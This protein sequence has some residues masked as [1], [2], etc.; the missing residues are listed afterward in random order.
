MNLFRRH[1][2]LVIAVI[3]ILV[4]GV[5]AGI[6]LFGPKPG[7]ASGPG[8]APG[9]QAQGGARPGGPGGPGGAA[10]GRGGRGGP[11]LV[12]A[13]PVVQRPFTDRVEVLGVA[14]GQQ[15]VTLTSNQAEMVTA[16]RFRPGQRVSKGQVLLDLKADEE[17]AQIMQAQAVVNQAKN[18]ADRWS[19]LADRGVAP[20]ASA[21]QYKS[22]YQTAQANLRAAQARRS[23]RV[24]RA[25][26]AGTI[27]LSDIAPGAL[28]SPGTAIATLDDTSV[29]HVDFDV[30]D[31]YLSVIRE[32]MAI[33]ATS[34]SYP[35]INRDGRI[36]R[37]DT[38]ID[39]R[40]RAVKA[41][42][43]FRNSDGKVK[44]GMLM[45]VGIQ[46][47]NRISMAVP[48]SA[49]QFSGD[50][51]YVYVINPRAAT[52][53]AGGPGQP[54]AGQGGPGAG[55]NAPAPEAKGPPASGSPGQTA[56]GPPGAMAGRG[57]GGPG[58]GTGQRVQAPPCFGSG[59]SS[60]GGRPGGPD[61]PGQAAPGAPGARGPSGAPPN[62][63]PQSKA[64]NAATNAAAGAQAGG[65]G[66][67]G[68][69]AGGRPGQAEQRPVLAGL[70]EGGYVEIKDGLRADEI[71]VSD[72]LNKLQPGQAVNYCA[73]QLPQAPPAQGAGR[74][75]RG[76]DM[77]GREGGRGGMPPGAMPPGAS[78]RPGGQSGG[79][80]RQ[81]R[82]GGTGGRVAGASS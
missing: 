56:G 3:L 18:D 27:G 4:M 76:G 26:F 12:G 8:G 23:D 45:R 22:A 61:Q 29:I 49:I 16:V 10:G 41:R 52:P 59:G 82:P 13:V 20:R 78:G 57:P 38:R 25:P 31:R 77:P 28:I 50:N 67:R 55:A 81:G 5:V 71:I 1:F 11:T 42:A 35:D 15:S 72:G 33:V 44:P 9:V 66:R 63:D 65:A 6:K 58:V 7:A 39:E 14:K 2:F 43:E 51:S 74:G 46:R 80:S 19:T 36:A 17:D 73:A 48:E 64:G 30:P 53:G 37:I 68:A 47:G 70:I 69:G 62:A 79:G 75:G 40:T 32:G 54:G 60:P 21:E 34:D 24:V